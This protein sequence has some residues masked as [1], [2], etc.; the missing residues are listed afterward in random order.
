MEAF[1]PDGLLDGIEWGPGELAIVFPTKT[2]TLDL[3]LLAVVT[4]L[5]PAMEYELSL[6]HI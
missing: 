2:A 5:R 3:G 4:P 1:P 6:I